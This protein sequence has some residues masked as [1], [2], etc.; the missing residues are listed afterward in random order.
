LP[1]GE[2]LWDR[3]YSRNSVWGLRNH[4]QDHISEAPVFG[5]DINAVRP[6]QEPTCGRALGTQSAAPLNQPIVACNSR[7][8]SGRTGLV[9]WDARRN[10]TGSP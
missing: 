3:L 4:K 1:Q 5:D 7:C 2:A 9:A 6:P 10:A 8:G